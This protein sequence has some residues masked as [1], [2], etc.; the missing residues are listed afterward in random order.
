MLA[1][2]I[3]DRYTRAQ[4]AMENQANE[5]LRKQAETIVK[6]SL[7]QATALFD[8]IHEGRHAAFGWGGNGYADPANHRWQ[9]GKASG[10]IPALLELRQFHNAE[11]SRDEI[12][13]YGVELQ[14]V[15]TLLLRALTAQNPEDR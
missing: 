7:K 10:A 4:Q 15:D 6:E 1:T 3:V 5:I 9:A 2:K 8:E 13:T 12:R 14:S 11:R